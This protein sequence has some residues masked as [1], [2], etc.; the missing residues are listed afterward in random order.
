MSRLSMRMWTTV[1]GALLSMG[2]CVDGASDGDSD[3]EQFLHQPHQAA[4]RA[5]WCDVRGG[6]PDGRW[7]LGHRDGHAR[8][9][10]QLDVVEPVAGRGD[11]AH[12]H[13]ERRGE[14]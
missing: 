10:Q 9:A 11:L 3:E 13:S 12:G 8:G 4:V 7:G 14:L 1:T 6:F 2:L 5:R